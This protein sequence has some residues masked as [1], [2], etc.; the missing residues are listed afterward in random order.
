[1]NINS[2]LIIDKNFKTNETYKSLQDFYY[3]S[4]NI[5]NEFYVFH[6]KNIDNAYKKL[7][8]MKYDFICKE[9]NHEYS[10]NLFGYNYD[11]IDDL[12]DNYIKKNYIKDVFNAFIFK[13]QF[14]D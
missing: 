14:E 2:H 3:L 4:I 10:H 1:M 8:E 5:N 13:V 9:F 11:D 12:Y 6:Y 7:Y